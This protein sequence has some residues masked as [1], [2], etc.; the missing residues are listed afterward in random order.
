MVE[1][2][3]LAYTR[4]DAE[5]LVSHPELV[6]TGEIVYSGIEA[7]LVFKSAKIPAQD[8]VEFYLKLDFGTITTEVDNLRSIFEQI[9]RQVSP[10]YGLS[11]IYRDIDVLSCSVHLLY[12]FFY[13]AITSYHLAVA[14]L[15]KYNPK[16]IWVNQL[17]LTPLT[18][19]GL[20]PPPQTNYENQVWGAMRNKGFVIKALEIPNTVESSP[21]TVK[22]G[23]LIYRSQYQHG[24]PQGSQE[25][26]WNQS[27]SS[28]KSDVLLAL[29]RNFTNNY[30]PIGQALANS[31]NLKTLDLNEGTLW[32]G[33]Y[34]ES[35]SV[36]VPF[37]GDVGALSE[38]Q[39]NQ[40]LNDDRFSTG[41]LD[42]PL[43]IWRIVQRRVDLLL[44][45]DI[46]VVRSWIERAY[47][48]LKE[49]RP[50]L[51]VMAEEVSLPART[52]GKVAQLQGIKKL[53][54]EHGAPISFDTR[55]SGKERSDLYSWQHNYGETTPDY[56]AVWGA[57]AQRYY[58]ES[59]GWF[60]EHVIPTGWP[61]IE[62][63][64]REHLSS[65]KTK[66]DTHTELR[67]LFLSTSTYKFSDYLY[68]T[69]FEAANYF[70]FELVIR[71]HATENTIQLDEL[72]C[73]IGVNI[74][75][76]NASALLQ[77][78]EESDIVLGAATS[79]LSYAIALKKPCIF[80][81]LLGMR[82]F[83]PYALEGAAIGVYD[84]EEL[85]PAIEKLLNDNEERHRQQAKQK[86]FTQQYLGPLDGK[87][88]ERIIN[89]VKSKI[90]FQDNFS[91]Y[92]STDALKVRS[93]SDMLR[94]D[95][96]C[97][98]NKPANF[99]GVDIYPGVGVDIV[100]DISKEFPF[101]DSSVDELRA[102]DIIEHLPDRIH[103]MN[104]IWRVCKPGAKVD[105]RVPSTD[106]RGAFQDPTHISFWNI[107]SFLYY[108]NEFPAYIELCR[109][110]GFK[111]EFKALKLEHEESADG[112]IHV[113]TELVVVKPVSNSSP[114]QIW[115]NDLINHQEYRQELTKQVT[116]EVVD[117]RT[118]EL[119][120]RLS[121]YAQQ[122]Q[123]DPTERSAIANLRQVR[124]QIAAQ[125]LDMSADRL[126]SMYAGELGR[127]HYLLLSIGMRN[128]L[129]TATE[130]TFVDEV[131]THISR[132]FD[133][134]KALQYLL[135]AM[136]YCRADQ[137]PLP[138]D[139]SC[140]PPWLLNDYLK[141]L[142]SPQPYFQELGEADNYY[143]YMQRWI[144]YLHA[145]IL[146][147]PDA[148]LSHEVVT[149]FVPI[150]N[151][152]PLY[153]NEAN[154]KDIYVKR[155]E[156]IE[157]FLKLKGY[158]V[159]Y[160]FAD[161][162]VTRKKIR[163]GILAAHFTATAETF[164]TLSAY[165]Y[166]SRDFEVILYPLTWDNNSL[167]QY[168]QSCANAV[169][170]LPKSLLDQVN[171]IRADDLDIILIGTNVTLVTNQICLLSLHRLA[172]IQVTSVSS[173]VT[174]GMRHVDYY[175][176]GKLTDPLIT[177]EEHY[178]E[179][180]VKLEGTAQ[181]FSYGPEQQQVNI[182]VDRESLG[183]SEETVVFTS[184]ANFFKIIPEL[185]DT[186][187]K[188]I[189]AVPNSVL[190]L[191]PFGPNWSNA[192]PKKAFF[193]QLSTKFEAH[194]VAAGRLIV[195]DPQPVPNR[196]EVKEYFN[197]ADVYLD[198]YPFAGTSS[199]IEPLEVGLPI[200]ARQGT[201][202]RSAMGAAMLQALDV[203]DLAADSEESY[204]Q[205]AIALGTNFELRQKKSDD[206]KKKM[207][208]NPSFLDS[209]SYSAQMGVLFQELFRKHQSTVLSDNFKLRD[210]NLIIFPD[211]RQSEEFICQ[212]LAS[213]IRAIATHPD[214]N[215][216]TLLID[217]GNISDEEDANLALSS[218]AMSLFMEEDL[219]VT[220]GPEISLVGNLG[221]L[222][223]QALLSCVHGRIVLE[224][225][226][227][228]AI[229][230]SGANNI[231][232][233]EL[234]YLAS[235]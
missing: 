92:S 230:D 147:E 4:A 103:T 157:L 25:T 99:T 134:P 162:S 197:I 205:L 11:L 85:I 166:I 30:A 69:L 145:S 102:H 24:Q 199:L 229:A 156:I 180:L 23:E 171:Y 158:E 114:N 110:Y 133:E 165:E 60:P 96:G 125:W 223:W 136:L 119:F 132:G 84:R 126:G 52:L 137:L 8:A 141:F 160:E 80:V 188:I 116:T 38:V 17:P 215:Q 13:E 93:K 200:I 74:K 187:A 61:W 95:I 155:A 181:C 130:Q 53:V 161:R 44:C 195:L 227:Q 167:E 117:E 208:S 81:D 109:R 225:E 172:R 6:K 228:Q 77:Q 218:I 66:L 120:S 198:S 42:Y 123:Q 173:V 150:A 75:I 151:F 65:E 105:I 104:E 21:N 184:G 5:W 68:E 76:D 62:R 185:I 189:A 3:Y 82:D 235:K 124:Y 169:K 209:R 196:E 204:I 153:F 113:K 37:T 139:F 224:N 202:F 26:T 192:Y 64:I 112:V 1:R 191:L 175:I 121:I 129:L 122:Y 63:E 89:F 206:I 100:A 101:P 16:E 87:A 127:A 40:L 201:C 107:N 12:Y 212:D 72:A 58:V 88:T 70:G 170:L 159:D 178:T 216:I 33:W 152:M 34:G 19:W 193:N 27:K 135:A 131:I 144:D 168:C 18:Q 39:V 106:G 9:C 98:T 90:D 94:V 148:L 234:N 56:V 179:K 20:A 174:T 182:K 15:K 214:R 28:L 221:A 111:G 59:L 146:S 219:D 29:Q 14:I 31:L 211:W 47:W 143:H 213:V 108:C 183:I 2:L 164:A 57:Y 7:H 163:L 186:W 210:I 22:A 220:E 154:L 233:S 226:N 207:R 46:P 222:Q 32:S 176:S 54:V 177:A 50:Q 79:V 231:A 49:V 194:G 217:T 71:P 36:P 91:S 83:M 128:E 203:P 190:L 86:L 97:G 73:R 118:Q 149:Q 35:S 232:I 115:G 41:F 142:F 67:L 51:I 45:F 138:H 55:I 78:I 10:D 140:I 43:D 48:V